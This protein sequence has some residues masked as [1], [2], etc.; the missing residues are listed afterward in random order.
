[1][2]A[3][4][5]PEAVAVLAK[6]GSKMGCST[7]SSA[8]WIQRSVTV[9]MQSSRSP[10]SGLGIA[11]RR[12]GLGRYVPDNRC[13]RIARH[14][15]RRCA[16]VWSMCRPSPPAAP[17]LARTRL[18]A[19]CRFSLVSA[20]RSSPDPGSPIHAADGELHRCPSHTGLHRVLPRTALLAQT[21]DAMLATS[22]RY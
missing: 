4:T 6:V 8:C 21:S 10:P 19:R 20:A 14:A 18:I 17:L 1:M 5:G 11:T 15:V 9:R 13:S 16:T 2:R 12:T 7:C 22:A 3:S